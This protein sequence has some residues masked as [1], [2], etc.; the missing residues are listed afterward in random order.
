MTADTDKDRALPFSY[1]FH[2]FVAYR[3]AGVCGPGNR[4]P[5][6]ALPVLADQQF[7]AFTVYSQESF[8]A[9]GTDLVCQVLMTENALFLAD[10]MD[11]FL[12]VIPDILH[13]IPPA[14]LSF[15]HLRKAQLPSCC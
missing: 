7:C 6:S 12:R 8:P 5:I 15:C 3:A 14:Q 2:A 4:F 1:Q 9:A 11:K 13:K 10:L